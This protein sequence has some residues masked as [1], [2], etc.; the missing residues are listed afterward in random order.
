MSTQILM[1]FS[2]AAVVLAL[3]ISERLPPEVTALLAIVALVITG[4]LEPAE[5]FASLGS[6]VIVMIGGVMLLT[7]ALVHN[8]VPQ[9]IVRAVR[10][11]PRRGET[12]ARTVLALAVS[13]VS[14]FI[15]NV[16]ATAMF[17]PVAEG[18]AGVFRGDRR[19]YLMPVAFASMAGG[20]C[21]LVGTSTNVAVA[22]RLPDLGLA[23]LGFF[24]LT[25]VGLAVVAVATA[26][27]VL[28]PRWLGWV[29]EEDEEEGADLREFLFEV[30]ILA[31]SPLAD[32]TLA[33][34]EPAR[35]LGL[36]VLAIRRGPETI[37]TPG[38]SETVLRGDLLLVKSRSERI[39]QLREM[40]GFR[41]VSMPPRRDTPLFGDGPRLIEATVSWNSPLI[42]RTVEEI[43]FRHQFGVSVLAIHRRDTLLAER[44]A[45]IPL[46]AGD[47]LLVFGRREM[48][49]RL[50]EGGMRLLVSDV[51]APGLERPGKAAW[52]MAIFLAAVVSVV[53]GVLDSAT[54][55][56]AGG[57][58]VVAGDIVPRSQVP[59]YVNMRFLILI[60]GLLALSR[61]LETSG[62]AAALAE[63]AIR[64]L[65]ADPYRQ[66]A[67]VF[68]LTVLLTQPLNNAAAALLVLPLAVA[69][70]AT[71]G[72]DPR[73]YAMAV[74]VAASCSF[75]TP[76][77]PACLLVY[78]TG[79]YRFR[80]FAR[81]GAPLTL[82][83]FAIVMLL[84]PRLWPF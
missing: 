8:G 28:A 80:D 3:L 44:V 26:Y 1:A 53:T 79:H 50:G 68:A 33:E 52:G 49:A 29:R 22:G 38:P 55:F 36:T 58:L 60:A 9:L 20:L 7:G 16:A 81:L 21:T 63:L 19:A 2:I 72:V 59:R 32:R 76:F 46:E 5:A 31:G 48:T 40:P 18:L 17:I 64:T 41:V 66:L 78:G 56:L 71:L 69:A 30:H 73:P 77:E 34:S 51:V 75:L 61:G 6:P 65:G 57:A 11:L 74:T 12:G 25:P 4:I 24:E 10:R 14:A 37:Q 27:L 13:A 83:V 35:R 47:V 42:G 54:A 67:A 70:A 23:P 15:N 62:A 45:H 43:D 39:S 84:V 82:A